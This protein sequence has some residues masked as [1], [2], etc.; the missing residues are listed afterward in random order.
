MSSAGEFRW[1]DAGAYRSPRPCPPSYWC[2]NSSC[3]GFFYVLFTQKY[4][5]THGQA[6]WPSSGLVI[7]ATLM[8]LVV[9]QLQDKVSVYHITLAG[10][11][12]ASLG[13]V[14]SAFAPNISWMTFTFGVLYGA[15][16][17]TALL[18]YTLYILLYF[19]KYSGTAFAIMWTTRAFSGMAGTQL[20]WHL[21]NTYGVEGCLL[22][23][24]GLLLNVVPF[25]MFIKSPSPT[26]ISSCGCTKRRRE[27]LYNPC[28]QNS[29][30][31]TKKMPSPQ[32]HN[33]PQVLP[34][35]ERLCGTTSSFARAM[36]SMRTWS[37]YVTVFYNAMCEYLF[38]TFNATV[39]AYGVDKG[40]TLE[41]SKQ[42]VVYNS[43]G[44]LVGRVIIPFATDK[45]SSSRSPAAVGSFLVAAICFFL[46]TCVSTYT[47]LVLAASVLGVAQG[48]VLCIK[49]V[50][51]SD[52]V[53]LECFTFCCGVGGLLSL[54]LWLSGPSII[55]FFREKNGSYDY[56]YVMLAI[57][58]LVHAVLLGLLT[59]REAMQRRQQLEQR[60]YDSVAQELQPT[61]ELCAV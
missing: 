18:G 7:A 35:P 45:I 27:K 3:Y 1:T 10:G 13:L 41:D 52:H 33:I 16:L 26:R 15:G 59:W 38:V 48:Y 30:S 11:F 25:T 5:I 55:G 44:L 49:S 37:F 42:V 23:T 54:P 24:G 53:G 57:L 56:L 39:V 34:P 40:C 21:A 46:I 17:G 12:L 29:L 60:F 43:M 28:A 51:V 20:L 32:S 50:I 9:S 31:K 58:C 6:A 19:K 61:K 22:I 47:G 36:A 2:M 8:C 4:G 14:A